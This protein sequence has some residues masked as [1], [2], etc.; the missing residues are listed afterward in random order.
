MG[1]QIVI[2]AS[3]S[4]RQD[5]VSLTVKVEVEQADSDQTGRSSMSGLENVKRDHT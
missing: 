2:D 4:D 5:V 1:P 3:N